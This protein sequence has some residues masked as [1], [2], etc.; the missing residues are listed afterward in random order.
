MDNIQVVDKIDTENRLDELNEKE[1]EDLFTRMVMGK[2]VI[3]DVDTSRGKFTVKYPKQRE[4]YSIGKLMAFRR[5]GLPSESFDAVADRINLI[6]ST[7]DVVV[8]DGPQWYKSAK[9]ENKNFS[10]LE[11]PDDKFLE[12][13]YQKAYTFRAKIYESLNTKTGKDNPGVSA[14]SGAKDTVDSGPFEGL[15]EQPEGPEAK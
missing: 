5:N 1:K 15:A 9:S 3:C 8:V 6:S 10:F 2:D 13:L 12:E 14:G 11:V 7:L 4:L